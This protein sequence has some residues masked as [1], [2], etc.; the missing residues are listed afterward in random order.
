MLSPSCGTVYATYMALEHNAQKY[1]CKNKYT[2]T[3][4]QLKK[5]KKN[6]NFIKV[7]FICNHGWEIHES[8][9]IIKTHIS[10][11]CFECAFE[12]VTTHTRKANDWLLYIIEK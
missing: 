9:A 11:K 12:C 2:F 3:K 7:V 5:D 4:K 10:F 6:I 8:T 1:A